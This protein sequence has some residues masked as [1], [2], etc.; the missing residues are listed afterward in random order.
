MKS[1]AIRHWN[2]SFSTHTVR[3]IHRNTSWVFATAFKGEMQRLGYSQSLEGWWEYDGRRL[4]GPLLVSRLC[5]PFATLCTRWKITVLHA[6]SKIR[7]KN[8]TCIQTKSASADKT[9]ILEKEHGVDVKAA[10]NDGWTILQIEHGA[11]VKAARNDGE[12]VIAF[13]MENSKWLHGRQ[14]WTE[15]KNELKLL[16]TLHNY[17]RN[18]L[19]RKSQPTPTFTLNKIAIQTRNIL[20]VV[21]E[22]HD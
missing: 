1:L 12:T 5:L 11:D 16:Q 7:S 6:P 15:K 22:C 3:N 14:W 9:T 21:A 8:A 17:S 13:C 19:Q 20:D 4:S 2:C 10:D 18:P